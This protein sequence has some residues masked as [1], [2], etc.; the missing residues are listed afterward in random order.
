MISQ[1]MSSDTL[2]VFEKDNTVREDGQLYYLRE[3]S[4]RAVWFKKDNNRISRRKGP[5]LIWKKSGIVEWY[6]DG[7]RH[8]VG[9]PAVYKSAL[10][11]TL[12]PG[13]VLCRSQHEDKFEMWYIHGEY[14][15]DD[16]PALIC[17][18]TIAWYKFGKLYEPT[19]HERMLWELRESNK[20]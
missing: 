14:H 3:S 10:N 17:H 4:E 12:L 20:K 6:E 13:S 16:G 8:R 2:K 5:A 15:R 18:D 1:R 9:G 19:A 7:V 11:D